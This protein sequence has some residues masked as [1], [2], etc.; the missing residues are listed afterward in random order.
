MIN[1]TDSMT[2]ITA[3]NLKGFFVDWG[4]PD[5]P[6]PET[7]LELLR[8]SDEIVLAIDGETGDV[9][10]FV[11]AITD[12]VLSAYIPLLEVRVAFQSQGI[13]GELMRRVLE[14]LGALYMVDVMCEPELQPFYERFGMKRSSGM[15]LRNYGFQSGVRELA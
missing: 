15:I 4:W 5:P 1:Y 3:V 10:G 12:R 13:G 11:T 8:N 7:H 6:P 9:V 14:K 2:E